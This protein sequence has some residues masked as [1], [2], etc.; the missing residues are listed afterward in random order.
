MSGEVTLRGWLICADDEQVGIVEQHLARHIALTRAEPGC[1]A[2]SV[3][4]TGDP[5]VWQ[6]AERFADRAAF[7]AHQK[8]VADSEWGRATS[9]IERD[10][11]IATAD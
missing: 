4:P 7:D 3:A 5:R 2:F 1:L 9:A 11:T 6:V 10:Y 8:R